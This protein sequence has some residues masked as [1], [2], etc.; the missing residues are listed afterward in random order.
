MSHKKEIGVVLI[1]DSEKKVFEDLE[2][3][4]LLSFKKSSSDFGRK[5]EKKRNKPVGQSRCEINNFEAGEDEL[6]VNKHDPSRYKITT[7]GGFPWNEYGFHVVS[8][9]D[10][11]FTH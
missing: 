4:A 8:Q 1:N 10:P 5:D 6:L 2:K 11:Q 3:T 9:Y 7:I